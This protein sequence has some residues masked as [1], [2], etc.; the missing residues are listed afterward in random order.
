MS[1]LHTLRGLM[2]L[3]ASPQPLS[4]S[5]L[6]M[7]DLQNTYTE[8]V[9]ELENVQPALDEAAQLLDRARSAGAKI[10]HIQHDAGEGTPYDVRAE[11][12]AIHRPSPRATVRR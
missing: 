4:Q 10:I 6:I 3:P 1:D 8:G 12:G 5:A 2:G 11:I 9:M 7:I